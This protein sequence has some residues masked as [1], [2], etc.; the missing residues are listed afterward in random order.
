[1]KCLVQAPL[2]PNV[3]F[4]GC[5][6]LF[7]SGDGG[8]SWYSLPVPK[9][10]F[11]SCVAAAGAGQGLVAAA[12]GRRGYPLVSSDGGQSWQQATDDVFADNK[13]H[14]LSFT[15]HTADGG[16][17]VACTSEGLFASEDGLTDWQRMGEGIPTTTTTAFFTC[18]APGQARYYFACGQEQGLYRSE[19]L[20]SGWQ[21][22]DL[23][24]PELR[25]KRVAVEWRNRMNVYACGEAGALKSTDG[26]ETWE[27]IRQEETDRVAIA[28][29]ATT[30]VYAA[31]GF[32][33]V[34]SPDSGAS[35]QTRQDGLVIGNWVSGDLVVSS[36]SPLDAWL[37]SKAGVY[38]TD[39]AGGS[40]YPSNY[41]IAAWS[42]SNVAVS[43]RA[44][45]LIFA[46]CVYNL[47]RK[48]Q[49]TDW[50]LWGVTGTTIDLSVEWLALDPTDDATVYAWSGSKL[51]RSVDMGNDGTWETVFEP[52]CGA[53]GLAIDPEN[54]D[55]LYLATMSRGVMVSRDGG[56]SWEES[57]SGLALDGNEVHLI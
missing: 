20:A 56:E 4:A 24:Q 37:G 43:D 35:W 21:E 34:I 11:V 55:N 57:N 45:G 5:D 46:N 22:L 53:R 51:I 48:T 3:L 14:W 38:R 50:Q 10:G 19:D 9:Q 8:A 33:L 39:D 7:K 26:G 31:G 30:V 44:P 52:G 16:S 41:G 6:A 36:Q 40:W 32:G 15:S 25:I 28:S 42:V 27:T 54:G 17:L 23:P 12:F 29:S 13:V 1:M 47:F 2:D 18:S 49:D